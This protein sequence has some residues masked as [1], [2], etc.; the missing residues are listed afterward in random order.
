MKTMIN[1]NRTNRV[2]IAITIFM[3]TFSAA[4]GQGKLIEGA[5]KLFESAKEK[6]AQPETTI[7]NAAYYCS[8]DAALE[9]TNAGVSTTAKNYSP[10]VTSSFTVSNLDVSYEA[11][12][13]TE[14]WM[15]ESFTSEIETAPAVESWMTEELTADLEMGV[16]F[17]QW[18][19]AP[20][21]GS[22]ESPVATEEW[23]TA[24]LT[25]S[26]EKPVSTEEWMTT[27]LSGNVEATVETESWMT[28][29]M[30]ASI[31]QV[32]EVE[33]WMTKLMR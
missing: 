16:E 7:V 31:K 20:L 32:P 24:P 9:V 21:T 33:S 8:G 19:T 15:T 2:A 11:E 17:E 29:P 1:T 22:F 10:V 27:P 23:M 3:M 26:F 25:E 28:T 14:T 12:L 6:I 4:N 18:M 5:V 30:Y 13:E